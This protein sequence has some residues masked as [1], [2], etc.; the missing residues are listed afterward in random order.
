MTNYHAGL[1]AVAGVPVKFRKTLLIV[2]GI[3]ANNDLYSAHYG[4]H[5]ALWG[6]LPV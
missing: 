5:A 3:A 4:S 6:A 1:D 2:A